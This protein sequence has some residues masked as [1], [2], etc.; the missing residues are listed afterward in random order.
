MMHAKRLKR[1]V[2]RVAKRYNFNPK[3]YNFNEFVHYKT[4]GNNF[5]CCDVDNVCELYLPFIASN[6]Y[7]VYEIPEYNKCNHK[8]IGDYLV[9]LYCHDKKVKEYT[10]FKLNTKL[11]EN[12]IKATY[13]FYGLFKIVLM[14]IRYY[15]YNGTFDYVDFDKMEEFDYLK[16]RRQA[17]NVND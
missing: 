14:H 4:I 3:N 6:I 7:D 12:N 5:A 13:H 11:E 1:I 10:L 8:G 16:N 15:R 2:S 17:Y 9:I